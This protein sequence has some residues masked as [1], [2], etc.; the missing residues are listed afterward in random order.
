MIPQISCTLGIGGG[1][2][3]PTGW[4]Q[5]D[6]A[7]AY[8]SAG[9]QCNRALEDVFEFAHVTGK[10]VA[11]ERGQCILAQHRRRNLRTSSQPPQYRLGKFRYVLRS[12]AKRWYAQ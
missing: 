1:G 9:A 12:F 4:P 2:R 3:V 8:F 5:L 10:G 7:G 6:I 11:F